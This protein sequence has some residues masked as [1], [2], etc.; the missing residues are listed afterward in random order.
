MNTSRYITTTAR[1]CASGLLLLAAAGACNAGLLVAQYEQTG[2]GITSLARADALIASRTPK[3]GVY[4]VINFTDRTSN[5]GEFGGDSAWLNDDGHGQT[6]EL[7][8]TFAV[9]VTG[10]VQIGAAGVYTFGTSNDDGARLAIDGN[11]L[12]ADQSPHSARDF[13]G[14]LNLTSGWHAIDLVY[15]ENLGAADLELFAQAGR[16]TSFNGGFELVGSAHGLQTS[17]SVPE[18]ASLALAAFALAGLGL[19]RRRRAA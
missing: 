11:T 15:Y 5:F 18:P 19:T 13:F 9:H 14:S 10:W 8:N 16:Y 7:N 12:I 2:G 1:R 6:S 4:S 17:E 3:T